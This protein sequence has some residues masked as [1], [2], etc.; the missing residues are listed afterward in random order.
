MKSKE[1]IKNINA[2]W[3]ALEKVLKNYIP[4]AYNPRGTSAK[5]SNFYDKILNRKCLSVNTTVRKNIQTLELDKTDPKGFINDINLDSV[6]NLFCARCEDL[7]I[8]F[9]KQQQQVFIKNFQ[10]FFKLRQLNLSGMNLGLASAKVISS[11]LIY[12]NSLS[13]V[14]LSKNQLGSKGCIEVCTIVKKN[15]SIIEINISNNNITNEGSSQIIAQLMCDHLVSIN[16]SSEENFRKNTLG[17][18]E[19]LKHLMLLPTLSFLNL[20]GV[21]IPSEC[22]EKILVPLSKNQTLVHLNLSNNNSI[23]S[24]FKDFINAISTSKVEELII[25][26]NKLK[27]KQLDYLSKVI[28]TSSLIKLNLSDNHLTTLGIQTIFSVLLYNKTL[29]ALNLSRNDLSKGIPRNFINF[30]DDNEYL[31]ELNLSGCFISNDT[32]AFIEGLSKNVGIRKL[33]LSFNDIKNKGAEFI[34]AGLSKN[35]YLK[36]LNLSFNKIKNKGGIA[37]SKA[38]LENN[39]LEKLNLKDNGLKNPAGQHL[40]KT[41]QVNSVLIKLDLSLNPIHI[42]YTH[43]I[44]SILQKRKNNLIRTNQPI[45]TRR[46]NY[47]KNSENPDY[48]RKIERKPNL[49]FQSFNKKDQEKN[50][51]KSERVVFNDTPQEISLFSVDKYE[52]IDNLDNF[53]KESSLMRYK[54]N[55]VIGLHSSTKSGL[56]NYQIKLETLNSNKKASEKETLGLKTSFDQPKYDIETAKPHKKKVTYLASEKLATSKKSKNP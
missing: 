25:S 14:N 12:C 56:E 50:V 54:E 21:G 24:V 53:T 22:F 35:K 13:R 33:I 43:S 36:H 17:Y 4:E 20:S 41:C 34:A 55:S 9:N 1:P 7:G 44:N 52:K 8:A 5:I 42:K 48:R 23:K 16:L 40:S 37:I 10:Q 46:I 18:C 51:K 6:K 38:L 15:Y 31:N 27:D 3:N 45:L 11:I 49:F 19:P 2:S 30:C 26:S 39:C 28:G 47:Q 32:Q 29:R